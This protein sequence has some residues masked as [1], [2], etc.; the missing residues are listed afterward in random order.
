MLK[1]LELHGFKSFAEK[2]RFEFPAGITVVVGPNGS[3]KSNIVD[4]MK[5]V[6]GEQSAKS[7]RG[8][9]M[10]DVIFKGS[11]EGSGHRVMNTAEAT[12]IF[13]N[14]DGRIPVDGPEVHVTRRVYRSGEGEYL[15]NGQP[16]RLKD[17]RDLFRGT[18]I[19]TDAYSLI[20]QGKVD[21]LLQASSKDRRAIFEEAAGISRFKAKKIEAQRRLERVEQNLL[22][23]SDIVDEVD[24]RL[25]S[26]RSQAGKAKR[27]REYSDRLQQLRTHVGMVNW[28][29]LTEELDA[30][31]SQHEVAQ[32]EAE[33]Y[34]SSIDGLE[35]R[36]AEIDA[37]LRESDDRLEQIES[38][39]SESRDL[40]ASLQSQAEYQR[41]RVSDLEEEAV[42][43]RAQ[44]AAMSGK[45]GDLQNRVREVEAAWT[46]SK[47]S[48]DEQELTTAGF[49]EE[50]VAID[51]AVEAARIVAETLRSQHTQALRDAAAIDR[52]ASQLST[53]AETN[54]R[55]LEQLTKR[56]T[57]LLKAL[58]KQRTELESLQGNESELADAI[59]EKADHIEETENQIAES[60]RLIARRQEDLAVL[61][62]RRESVE[63]RIKLLEEQEAAREGV[64]PGVRQILASSSAGPE[65]ADSEFSVVGLVA[66]NIT[67]D[68]R[69]AAL[70]DAALGSAAQGLI[71]EC[72][73]DFATLTNDVELQ[74]RVE[75]FPLDWIQP[76]RRR[77]RAIDNDSRLLGR[78][79]EL[80][81]CTE[82]VQPLIQQLL[83]ATY[84][85]DADV[86]ELL[87]LR[88]RHPDV[89]LVSREGDVIT[90]SGTIS[91]ASRQSS[92]GL[93]SRRS[94][95]NNLRQS[96]LRLQERITASDH[97]VGQLRENVIQQEVVIRRMADLLDQLRE[98]LSDQRVTVRTLMQQVA[99]AAEEIALVNDERD[100][101]L[102]T[103]K[104][105]SER[106]A[107]LSKEQQE[108]ASAVTEFE[109][110]L[111]NQN[112]ELE[113]NDARRRELQGQMHAAEVELAKREQRFQ[114][115][116][117]QRRQLEND[118][119]ERT[120]ALHEAQASLKRCFQRRDE[121]Q[122]AILMASSQLAE[123]YLRLE[124]LQRQITES[125][126]HRR[127]GNE[128]RLGAQRELQN[129]RK[130]LKKV[131]ATLHQCELQRAGLQ[132]ERDSL[133]ERLRD[134]Y[135]IDLQNLKEGTEDVEELAE[136]EAIEAE[137]DGLRRKINNIGAV[138]M[139][140]LDELDEL[141]ERFEG[142][143][144]QYQDLT[145]AKD[146]LERII[147]RI[148]AD[149]RRLFIETLEAIRTNFQSLYRKAF[150]GGSADIVL[151][152]GVDVLESGVDIRATP[153]GK[154]TFDNSLLSGGE[155]ALTAV[156]LLL[157]IF[158]FRPSPF[159]VLDEVDA[160]FDEANVGRFVEVL[161]EFLGWTKF[162]VV[163][164]SKKTMTAANTLYG[165]TMQ[166]SGISK[167]V[168][169][170]FE[171]VTD[172][173]HILESAIVREDGAA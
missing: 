7:L 132:H 78:A 61:R 82:Q 80:V 47:Q 153:P 163:T 127:Q 142:L 171:D 6:L 96:L 51:E 64:S 136:R 114:T 32:S 59:Q 12:I 76:T 141:E 60:R 159:C 55:T 146:S 14:S 112:R 111:D 152:E 36:C 101:L 79:D 86:A 9:E 103:T 71:V 98:K 4:A 1:A 67:A 65:F 13:D 113:A 75:L 5:W 83:G 50:F 89:T 91:L 22:R 164:H 123:E 106:L 165:I 134:D 84:I 110:K 169:V 3:G 52:E 120:N 11:G 102:D 40:I 74:G 19:G 69:F 44:V 63:E 53:R 139:E 128:E 155:K 145:K 160:P 38:A 118:A 58:E 158:Q 156:A 115:L 46:A 21:R 166:Q 56:Q 167:R 170:R 20:E 95:L 31:Q 23:L 117:G 37:E 27:Y 2:T 104:R 57:G 68:L 41:H 42:L 29:R 107:Q 26:I 150:G 45:A 81:E 39:R 54:G 15:I 105:E 173:G 18:G 48:R 122:R 77:P 108:L 85:L 147:S 149:S 151:E 97:E 100:A 66:E 90:P 135:G 129:L 161:H 62:G 87:E 168:S 35:S 140:A 30:I 88:G 94:E 148:N 124:D 73:S 92:P 144:Q 28:R 17:I 70:I 131:E 109:E 24:S 154:P 93:V 10:A 33:T 16:C 126:R 116:D 121:S 99:Q 143:S 34:L 125:V 72:G 119:L 172:D 157:A 25:R 162:V 137:I 43:H 133:V 138:N 49:R 8:K 130:Q